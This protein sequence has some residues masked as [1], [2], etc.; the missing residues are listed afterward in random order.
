MK[1]KKHWITPYLS[2]KSLYTKIAFLIRKK[3]KFHIDYFSLYI[4]KKLNYYLF[5]LFGRYYNYSNGQLLNNKIKK[6]KYFKKSKRSYSYIISV[7]NK[8]LHWKLSSVNVFYCKNFN[9]RNYNWIKRYFN[10][11][12]PKIN[13]FICSSSWNY[14]T[15]KKKRIKKKIYRNIIKKSKSV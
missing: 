3:K 11:L 2:V 6:V 15:I 1:L 5:W 8:K 10:T 14:I 12:Y 13:Y 7:L 4:H 9:L